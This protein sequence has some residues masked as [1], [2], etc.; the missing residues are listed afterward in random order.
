MDP[1]QDISNT[2]EVEL[3]YRSFPSRALCFKDTSS[4][5]EHVKALLT[6]VL[7]VFVDGTRW[8]KRNFNNNWYLEKT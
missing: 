4:S 3:L 5:F 2:D 7:K 1:I 6:A 8:D